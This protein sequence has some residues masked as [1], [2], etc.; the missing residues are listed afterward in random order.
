METL[1]ALKIARNETERARAEARLLT[2]DE[3]EGRDLEIL[4]NVNSCGEI[5]KRGKWQKRAAWRL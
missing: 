2:A 4:D 1:A 3:R 5:N